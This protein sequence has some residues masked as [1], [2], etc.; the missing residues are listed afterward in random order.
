MKSFTK[1]TLATALQVMA[2]IILF[3]YPGCS[4]NNN[5]ASKETLPATVNSNNTAVKSKKHQDKLFVGSFT[6][7]FIQ[8][9]TGK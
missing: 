9:K 7:S 6:G 2:V 4:S 5:N 3:G 1:S 8:T